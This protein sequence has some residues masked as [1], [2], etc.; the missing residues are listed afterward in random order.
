MLLITTYN[1]DGLVLGTLRFTDMWHETRVRTGR[2][3]FKA[4]EEVD[5][6]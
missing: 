6:R 2:R 3:F 1:G 4:S 5:K